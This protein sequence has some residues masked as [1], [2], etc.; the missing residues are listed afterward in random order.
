MEMEG[1]ARKKGLVNR[2]DQGDYWWELRPCVY[3]QS[4]EVAENNLGESINRCIILL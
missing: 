2:D 3:Y 1:H 4:F